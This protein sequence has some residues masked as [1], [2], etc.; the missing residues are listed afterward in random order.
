MKSPLRVASSRQIALLTGAVLGGSL[1]FLIYV[2]VSIGDLKDD[3]PY[4]LLD[5]QQAHYRIFE[6]LVALH[7]MVQ[8]AAYEQGTPRLGPIREQVAIARLH[9]AG[10]EGE[11]ARGG[12]EDTAGIHAQII[13]VLDD[14]DLWLE[15]GLSG[16]APDS[17]TVLKA[18]TFRTL[19]ASGTIETLL[20]KVHDEALEA[21]E[22]NV[23][24]LDKFRATLVPIVAQILIFGGLLVFFALR[25]QRMAEANRLAQARLRDAIESLP[26]TFSLFDNNAKLVLFNEKHREIYPGPKEVMAVGSSYSDMVKGAAESGK[27][28]LGPMEAKDW[29]A[30]REAA[31]R[32]SAGPIE[33]TFADGKIFELDEWPTAE[34]GLVTFGTDVTKV[35]ARESEL[36]R[37]GGELRMAKEEA[38]MASRSKSE[39]LANVSHELRTP[40]NAIIGFS[41]I[42]ETELFGPIAPEQYRE[43][44][45]DIHSSGRHLLSLINDILD[46]SKVEAGK[47]ELIESDIDI[48]EAVEAMMRLVRDRAHQGQVKLINALPPVMPVLIGDLRAFKQILLNLLSNAVKFTEAGGTVTLE[49]VIV[50]DGSLELSVAD[51][52]IGMSPSDLALALTPFGQV[53]TAFSRRADGTGLGLPLSERLVVAHGGTLDVKSK[54]AT[55][56]RVTVRFP[57]N[58]LLTGP[59]LSAARGR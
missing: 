8:S 21:L 56:T 15:N 23:S 59:K 49:A 7:R 54:L 22:R 1:A 55:G 13:P 48:A 5:R 26:V 12:E 10:I 37:I 43:Y 38:E 45:G 39:F 46:L 3:L 42:I 31:F 36:L 2:A 25:A 4:E 20:V 29:C 6:D 33:I 30:V 58:R 40:L 17:P 44:A 18:M 34:G 41:E 50:S 35:R 16:L 32:N 9:L 14:M 27:L 51:T 52:G 19:D 11:A 57:A 53:D 28:D 47:F 24:F